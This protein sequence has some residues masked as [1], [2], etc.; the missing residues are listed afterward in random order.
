M[1]HEQTGR[2]R[3][4]RAM[5]LYATRN[6]ALLAVLQEPLAGVP[7]SLAAK[8][9][10]SCSSAATRWHG[11][12][13]GCRSLAI[14]LGRCGRAGRSRCAPGAACAGCAETPTRPAGS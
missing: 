8:L 2:G 4:V 11:S 3:D 1:Y 14:S 6:H 10:S 7:A 13:A 9:A 5:N 12:R